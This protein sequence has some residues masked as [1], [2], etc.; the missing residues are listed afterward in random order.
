MNTIFD[1]RA[2]ADYLENTFREYGIVI[3]DDHF[4]YASGKHGEAYVN[5]DGIYVHP[6]LLNQVTTLM[7]F[8]VK[9]LNA[10][11]SVIAGPALGGIPLAALLG[12]KWLALFGES[13]S[14]IVIEKDETGAYL[15][16]RGYDKIAADARVLLVEDILTTGKSV[17]LCIDVLRDCGAEVVQIVNIW[18]RG[19]EI[20]SHG[21]PIQPLMKRVLPMYPEDECPFCEEGRP[22]NIK[23][24]KGAQF[25]ARTSKS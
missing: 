7:A 3:R 19:E 16:K 4:V 21:V 20:D 18:Q 5:K 1:T 17:G 6:E 2:L 22:V 24:G 13:K 15:L 9:N 23:L 14:V 25:M 12:Q 11:F 8:M 10:D